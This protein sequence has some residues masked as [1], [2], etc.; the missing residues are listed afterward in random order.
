MTPSEKRAQLAAILHEIAEDYREI[1]ETRSLVDE[2]T[3][4]TNNRFIAVEDKT[5]RAILGPLLGVKENDR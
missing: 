2:A 5:M 3:K 1:A 4:R